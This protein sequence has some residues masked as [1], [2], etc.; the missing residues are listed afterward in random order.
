MTTRGATSSSSSSRDIDETPTTPSVRTRS[1]LSQQQ[2]Q[3]PTQTSQNER[4]QLLRRSNRLSTVTSSQQVSQTPSA[5]PS[6]RLLGISSTQPRQVTPQKKSALRPLS[7]SLGNSSNS[8]NSSSSSINLQSQ[9][10]LSSQL[11]ANNSHISSQQIPSTVSTRRLDSPRSSS[12]SRGINV[13]ISMAYNVINDMSNPNKQSSQDTA[14][15]DVQNPQNSQNSQLPP[16]TPTTDSIIDQ[17][18]LD[19]PTT[20]KKDHKRVNSPMKTPST[21]TKTPPRRQSAVSTPLGKPLRATV[22]PQG[23]ASAVGGV[24]GG[25][26]RAARLPPM[27][28]LSGRPIGMGDKLSQGPQLSTL[29]TSHTTTTTSAYVTTPQRPKKEA[30]SL[31]GKLGEKDGKKD[32]NGA[33]N[34]QSQQVQQQ[35]QQTR[36]SS[37]VSSR[38]T[39]VAV[40]TPSTPVSRTMKK[41]GF[42]STPEKKSSEPL[43]ARSSGRV[44]TQSR[45]TANKLLSM[46]DD[47]DDGGLDKGNGGKNDD[48]ND[49]ND[50]NKQ[51]NDQIYD[52]PSVSET[53]LALNTQSQHVIIGH[54]NHLH[55]QEFVQLSSLNNTHF[56]NICGSIQISDIENYQNYEK[57]NDENLS[58]N[59][60]RSLDTN[61]EHESPAFES[62]NSSGST[63][64]TSGNNIAAPVT[65]P[66]N[67]YFDNNDNDDG[68]IAPII[69]K[70]I[71]ARKLNPTPIGNRV[72]RNASRVLLD[73]A[74][75]AVDAMTGAQKNP[76]DDKNDECFLEML[77]TNNGS[78]HNLDQLTT[79]TVDNHDKDCNDANT[80]RFSLTG[81]DDDDEENDENNRG[82]DDNFPN[83][84][85]TQTVSFPIDLNNQSI[86]R[87]DLD[88][89]DNDDNDDN[90]NN[91]N[92]LITK[93]PSNMVYRTQTLLTSP[94]LSSSPLLT[95]SHQSQLNS[96][97]QLALQS[98]L[99]DNN[100]NNNREYHHNSRSSST[101]INI[102]NVILPLISTPPVSSLKTLAHCGRISPPRSS[103][104]KQTDIVILDDQERELE[105]KLKS[106]ARSPRRQ[107]IRRSTN[108]QGSIVPQMT[109]PTL[110]QSSASVTDHLHS[111]FNL[112]DD[113]DNNKVIGDYNNNI[114]GVSGI[115]NNNDNDNNGQQQ[116]QQQQ[117]H[118]SSQRFKS[119]LLSSQR[120]SSQ[121]YLAD[122][123]ATQQLDEN[124]DIV[125][126]DVPDTDHYQQNN[127]SYQ[128]DKFDDDD[129]DDDLFDDLAGTPLP[130]STSIKLV[131][132]STPT[133]LNNGGN[134]SQ[135]RLSL[136]LSS[137]KESNNTSLDKGFGGLAEVP[138]FWSAFASE[139]KGDEL[140]MTD[141]VN[142]NNNNNNN[143]PINPY[144]YFEMCLPK[145]NSKEL[146]N[147]WNWF[148]H[149]RTFYKHQHVH[150]CQYDNDQVWNIFNSQNNLYQIANS[151]LTRGS[152]SAYTQAVKRIQ[153]ELKLRK[154]FESSLHPPNHSQHSQHSQHSSPHQDTQHAL[155][156]YGFPRSPIDQHSFELHNINILNPH[157]Q[158]LMTSSLHPTIPHF[159]A[160][161]RLLD[162]NFSWS[163]CCHP[164]DVMATRLLLQQQERILDY[165]YGVMYDRHFTQSQAIF[166]RY[167]LYQFYLEKQRQFSTFTIYSQ[168]DYQI[169]SS[170]LNPDDFCI[171]TNPKL[172]ESIHL[173][174][175]F[176]AGQQLP[177]KSQHLTDKTTIPRFF[178]RLLEDATSQ[179][180]VAYIRSERRYVTYYPTAGEIVP[181]HNQASGLEKDPEFPNKRLAALYL[182]APPHILDSVK[183]ESRMNRVEIFKS[184]EHEINEMRINPAEFSARGLY[185][186]PRLKSRFHAKVNELQRSTTETRQRILYCQDLVH[187]IK[188]TRHNLGY[189]SLLE[190]PDI[191]EEHGF[192]YCNDSY[193]MYHRLLKQAVDNEAEYAGLEL[194]SLLDED[195]DHHYIN[196]ISQA[197]IECTLY[198]ITL[199]QKKLEEL[200]AT[201]RSPRYTNFQDFFLTDIHESQIH[202]PTEK[203]NF[204]SVLINTHLGEYTYP[205]PKEFTNGT[206][207]ISYQG[208]E[209]YG[210]WVKAQARARFPNFSTTQKSLYEQFVNERYNLHVSAWVF[211]TFYVQRHLS[212]PAINYQELFIDNNPQNDHYRFKT[213]EFGTFEPTLRVIDPKITRPCIRYEKQTPIGNAQLGKNDF[214]LKLSQF[215]QNCIE[216]EQNIAEIPRKKKYKRVRFGNVNIATIVSGPDISKASLGIG[217]TPILLSVEVLSVDAYETYQNKTKAELLLVH[218]T[219]RRKHWFNVYTY[220][221]AMDLHIRLGNYD[222][223]QAGNFI[224]AL[225]KTSYNQKLVK[226]RK[227]MAQNNQ[228]I[229]MYPTDIHNPDEL[230]CYPAFYRNNPLTIIKDCD[231]NNGEPVQDHDGEW[232]FHHNFAGEGIKPS[233]Y[234][235]ATPFEFRGQ[236]GLQLSPTCYVFDPI[237]PW[238]LFDQDSPLYAYFVDILCEYRTI[239]W[240]EHSRRNGLHNHNF[241][242]REQF[243]VDNCDD[244]ALNYKQELTKIGN[245]MSKIDNYLGFKPYEYH[246]PYNSINDCN[247]KQ[248]KY[249][250]SMAMLRFRDF[251][252]SS[253]ESYEFNSQTGGG[254][255]DESCNGDLFDQDVVVDVDD[256]D[257][258][259]NDDYEE[260]NHLSQSERSQRIAEIQAYKAL[261]RARL[262]HE[263]EQSDSR[264]N[265][266][267]RSLQE[268]HPVALSRHH[269]CSCAL[270]GINCSNET[271]QCCAQGNDSTCG[272]PFGTFAYLDLK[273][274]LFNER[275]LKH[276]AANCYEHIKLSYAEWKNIYAEP[277]DDLNAPNFAPGAPSR[278]CLASDGSS[279]DHIAIDDPDNRITGRGKHNTKQSIDSIGLGSG[280]CYYGVSPEKADE[281]KVQTKNALFDLGLPLYAPQVYEDFNP[282]H[283]YNTISALTPQDRDVGQ[284][285]IDLKEFLWTKP[286]GCFAQ[287]WGVNQDQDPNNNYTIPSEQSIPFKSRKGAD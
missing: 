109:P 124:S 18:N 153:L 87:F 38:S 74:V 149:F 31:G 45:M 113:D 230:S 112:G 84:N 58:K 110:S 8:S 271:C 100:N 202:A 168:I 1:Q 32:V 152:I 44:N 286:R 276:L 138:S 260:F 200:T 232:V 28:P 51:D 127:P 66:Q 93:Q 222:G 70:G 207:S 214:E 34:S 13:A 99:G 223:V 117:Q 190:S 279:L 262:Q 52:N 77:T 121:T 263:H 98:P 277:N 53:S 95:Q 15:D 172:H 192:Q 179:L 33:Q 228:H 75:A 239:H 183:L 20:P 132:P 61:D 48:G 215:D 219:V 178:V 194:A 102:D 258:D 39:A 188:T 64:P 248:D 104:Q 72:K 68:V 140:T 82:D 143:I 103:P 2:Q 209:D 23:G 213:A 129:D 162:P 267:T 197:H 92:N 275:M 212:L 243:N 35:Q 235:G 59:K 231:Y 227:Q 229:S 159:A 160:T 265:A 62:S 210:D 145:F 80:S 81:L 5:V 42:Q 205:I 131:A 180:A 233:R 141:C 17:S 123:M 170:P 4:N 187:I 119:Q 176:Y 47:E 96:L 283:Q 274:S 256:D 122:L 30:K 89:V 94:K 237:E 125:V 16:S 114:N 282:I 91:N 88:D 189:M 120:L 134:F 164:E 25:A 204:L 251:N 268:A 116:Q 244:L 41:L 21:P 29:G 225:S 69:S 14:Q 259:D 56:N 216:N 246:C 50:G 250:Y 249:H 106:L 254:C 272:N 157:V 169:P 10:L 107:S 208:F 186:H 174:Q 203:Y 73:G 79:Q 238:D 196:H 201:A 220:V 184:T 151:F 12:I 255:T 46:S 147:K 78:S 9:Q 126:Y 85:Y 60:K 167:K 241:Y 234:E 270:M 136:V 101:N 266:H 6:T 280:C 49:G 154:Q 264:F 242:E 217:L 118:S 115:N 193:N 161:D 71:K 281:A 63:S 130:S 133:L 173:E 97:S 144:E 191:L 111:H 108:S 148:G 37:R 137:Q 171:D 27:T 253:N 285:H 199:Y 146:V 90:D 175:F 247:T 278:V 224:E 211:A 206:F 7:Q 198:Q 105:L 26:K 156:H 57:N 261:R 83:Q 252:E 182:G 24:T 128:C 76:K 86:D 65:P 166:E 163:Y 181:P 185:I 195:P 236:T 150:D 158:Q 19:V 142:N 221:L 273:S 218:D 245:D 135:R 54:D 155:I 36:G 287:D 257:D 139:S 40:P 22:A 269:I 11:D 284:F 43:S 165:A 226:I 55:S 177:T 67:C 240:N 3:I